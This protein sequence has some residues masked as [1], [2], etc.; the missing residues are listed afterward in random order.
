MFGLFYNFNLQQDQ[1]FDRDIQLIDTPGLFDTRRDN[2][3]SHLEIIKCIQMTCPGLHCFLLIVAT[4]KFTKEHKERVESLFQYFGNDVH[5]FFIIVFTKINEIESDGITQE[6]YI[7]TLP[8]DF[9]AII[10]KC[11]QRIAFYGSWTI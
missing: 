6:D 8:S 4:G 7:T 3:I 5:R 1:V 2:K 11:N 10:E 9:K